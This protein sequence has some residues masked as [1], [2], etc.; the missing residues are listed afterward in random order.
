MV[1]TFLLDIDCVVLLQNRPIRFVS[2]LYENNVF[3]T[4]MLLID[5]YMQCSVHK[6][7]NVMENVDF[8]C[9]RHFT[10]FGVIE[11]IPICNIG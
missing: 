7:V 9:K 5:Y 6:A 2:I 3:N 1:E 10:H 8:S 4:A 11:S